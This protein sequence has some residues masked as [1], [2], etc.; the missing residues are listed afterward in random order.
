LRDNN[1]DHLKDAEEDDRRAT[2]KFL[3]KRRGQIG[4]NHAADNAII[5]EVTCI[6]FMCHEKL[7]VKLGPLINFIVGRNGSGKSAVLTAV[8][9]C[10]GGKASATNRGASLK[11]LIKEGTDHANLIVKL[12]N[13]GDDAY[14]RDL[15]GNAIIVERHFS[16]SGTS[17][18]RLKSSTG[19]TISIKKADVDDVIE[20]FQ[21][22]VDNPM[23]VL[24]QDAAKTFIQTSTP[25]QKYTFFIEGTQLQQLDNDFRLVSDTCD[26]IA[27]K[28]NDGKGSLQRLQKRAEEAQERK[29]QIEQHENMRQKARVYGNQ[30]AWAQ[31]EEEEAELNQRV[32][33]VEEIQKKI[34]QAARV[35]QERGESYRIA[36][37]KVESAQVDV[38]RLEDEMTPLREE[39][40]VAKAANDQA[41]VA[42]QEAQAEQRRIQ[43]SI[44][45]NKTKAASI[46]RDIEAEEKRIEDANG[47]A[48][49]RKQ[50]EIDEARISVEMAKRALD[51]SE[52]EGKR[53]DGN[54][55]RAEKAL[56]EADVPLSFK[57]QEIDACRGRIATLKSGNS[58]SGY[59]PKILQVIKVI[60]N[61]R[62]FKEQPIGPMG[63]H[64]RLLK[65]KWSP[66]I[67]QTLNTMLNAFVV[68]SKAD[69]KL[70]SVLLRQ[71]KV[72]NFCSIYI[73]NHHRIDTTSHEPDPRYDT[74]L[75]VLE[76][77]NDLVKHQLII[78]KAIE[79]SLLVWDRKEAYKVMFEGPRPR[80][81]KC[82]FTMHDTNKSAGHRFAFTGRNGSSQEMAPIMMRLNSRPR[83][84]TDAES[85][86]RFQ[87]DMLQQ[88]EGERNRLQNR[89]GSLQQELNNCR[90]SVVRHKRAH[91]ILRTELQR[92]EDRVELLESELDEVNI[93]DGRLDAFRADL[94][95][96]QR[97]V[98]MYEEM[99]GGQ[100]LEKEK[101]NAEGLIKKRE[102][103]AV[104][105]R[106][107]E[108]K[109]KI[110]KAESKVT[111]LGQIRQ[112][113]VQ[114]KNI[115]IANAEALKYEKLK[116]E[117]RREKQAQKVEQWIG[118]ASEICE[119][120]PIEN[121]ETA[122]S[123]DAKLVKLRETIRK[124]NQA[125]GATDDEINQA[126][127]AA[128]EAYQSHRASFED[129]EDL[130]RLL[131]KSFLMRMK[132]FWYFQR[133]I[134][135]RS[136][137][138]F[139]YLLS[140]R[141]FRGK[142]VIDHKTKQ[143]EVHVEPDETTKSGKG[144]QT[145]T[146]SGG[147]KSFSSICLLLSLWEA[148]G[149]PLRC[150]DE[151]DVFMDDVNR[152]VSSRM[153]VS[154]TT[155]FC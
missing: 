36:N 133:H 99:Y 81:V 100:A 4:E 41:T 142:L 53:L 112:I 104:R 119:R 148:M 87:N 101:A 51:D 116:A 14:H 108:H 42:V 121:N 103:K 102:L 155:I 91:G 124:R 15:Y 73:G 17:G 37:E 35:S 31:V 56:T 23:N 94:V 67:E 128:T 72:D 131:K 96:A 76:I 75:R 125:L 86:M 22:Q 84:K 106:I 139:N 89:K 80:N 7:Y 38:S 83:M 113:E 13:E 9:L 49:G 115:A 47:G 151:F 111:R 85:Q 2:Q 24:T 45:E 3:A 34:D 21:L 137:I 44:K 25:A 30:L 54:V 40:E 29:R 117:E 28:L 146:L 48:S 88:L 77:D 64:M 70:L 1:W 63:M 154:L 92:A 135:S 129:M 60:Q 123:L 143:L 39:E 59:D 134:S 52:S 6:N 126:C 8:T 98:A 149:A 93:E 58:M 10:L 27:S 140:E 153:I 118:Q 46:Q 71:Y 90:Q 147:E 32:E 122:A 65:P 95:E 78:H 66:L 114:E 109:A 43:G 18:Y 105:D 138:N 62:G 26:Q 19:R 12:K 61:H 55:Q 110:L 50:A 33:A 130:L 127:I 79:Q 145:K 69:Q 74:I 20:Y 141:A 82:C 57:V 107:E 152:D 97:D 16:R 132:M 5:E 11:S 150:L 120:V 68:T 136:R 144:R